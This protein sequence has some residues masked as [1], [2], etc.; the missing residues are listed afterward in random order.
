MR[1]NNKFH[2]WTFGQILQFLHVCTLY[3]LLSISL[4]GFFLTLPK[5]SRLPR[6]FPQYPLVSS[7]QPWLTMV[8]SIADYYIIVT[9]I[10]LN[11]AC[12]PIIQLPTTKPASSHTFY[13]IK[14]N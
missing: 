4:L 3:V 5:F 9:D 7:N 11:L 8:N 1:K 6:G 2:S 10:Y 13:A 14:Q 12:L